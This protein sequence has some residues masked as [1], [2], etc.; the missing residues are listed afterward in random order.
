[1]SRNVPSLAMD[2]PDLPDDLFVIWSHNEFTWPH[3]ARWTAYLTDLRT[4]ALR[5][6]ALF[7]VYPER[8]K[9]FATEHEARTWLK[10]NERLRGFPYVEV[11]V[12][13]VAELKRRRGFQS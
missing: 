7:T 8:A 6:S 3:P 5:G 1:M 11:Q 10:E 9:C 4:H 12:T 2:Y 13:T